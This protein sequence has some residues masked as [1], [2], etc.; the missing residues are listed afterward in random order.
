MTIKEAFIAELDETSVS[1]AT[2]EKTLLD[3]TLTGSV[4]YSATDDQKKG[5]D[6]CIVDVLYRLYTRNDITE[7]GFTKSHPDFL[8]KIEARLLYLAKKYGVTEVLDAIQK[9]APTINDASNKW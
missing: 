3:N 8:R 6:L 5:I 7:G 2:I 9:A 4:T 1:D